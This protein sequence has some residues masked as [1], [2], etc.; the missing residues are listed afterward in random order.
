MA[1]CKSCDADII[2]ATSA[3][4]GKPMP[5][6]ATPVTH[7]RGVFAIVK[8]AASKYTPEDAKLHRDRY[9]CHFATCPNADQ[10]RNPR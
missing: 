1:A 6:D 5:F 8:G 7:D 3:R 10:H 2:W 4:S 9:T